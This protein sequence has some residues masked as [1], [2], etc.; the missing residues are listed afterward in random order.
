MHLRA[1]LSVLV[2]LMASSLFCCSTDPVSSSDSGAAEADSG[3]QPTS[4]EEDRDP[5]PPKNWILHGVC[6]F[7]SAIGTSNETPCAQQVIELKNASGVVVA[8]QRSNANGEFSFNCDVGQTYRVDIPPS[9]WLVVQEPVGLV[10]ASAR[11]VTLR[12]RNKFE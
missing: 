11:G 9:H 8:R 2:I 6:F 3:S 5:S 10:K 4:H 1:T 12:L 7:A